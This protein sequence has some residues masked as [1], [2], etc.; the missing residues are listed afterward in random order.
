M[1]DSSTPL[2]F[3]SLELNRIDD[4]AL[5]ALLSANEDLARYQPWFDR[6]RNF[7][8]HQL[9]DEL[10]QYQHDLSVV[11][12]SAW[13][14]LFDETMSSLTFDVDGEEMNAEQTLN[15][16]SDPDREKRAAGAAA[17]SKTFK[18]NLGL[19]ARITNTLAK[20][21]EIDD[22]WR[23]LDTPQAFR[24][25]SNQVEPEVVQALR[26]AVVNAYP[27]LSHRYYKLKAKWLGLDTMQHWDRNAPLPTAD[28][29]PILWTDARQTVMDAYAGFHPRMAEIAEPFFDKGWIDAEVK[30][31][32]SPRRLRPPD[33]H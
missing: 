2:V 8:P 29:D 33:G 16:L 15:L 10:E 22:R 1:N 26:D 24:H 20:E 21:K 6:L 23:K 13:N 28:N 30:P 5:N 17:L 11:G 7:R 12:T 9:S 4:D 14:R 3:F 25:L 18:A 27:N 31:G 32:K 19:F